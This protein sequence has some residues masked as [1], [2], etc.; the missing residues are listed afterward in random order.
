MHAVERPLIFSKGG[1]FFMLEIRT[2]EGAG[3]E[4]KERDQTA[5]GQ[6]EQIL[7]ALEG[8]EYGSLQITVHG[9]QVV[10]IDRTEKKRFTMERKTR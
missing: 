8:L 3:L 6:V 9:G 4:K 2:K 1:R 10:Q 5:A 7:K